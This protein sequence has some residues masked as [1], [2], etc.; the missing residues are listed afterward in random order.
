MAMNNSNHL[1]LLIISFVHHGTLLAVVI[2]LSGPLSFSPASSR[3]WAN[4]L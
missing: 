1:L 4:T 3:R 2:G